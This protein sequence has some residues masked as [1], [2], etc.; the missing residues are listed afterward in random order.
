MWETPQDFF[1]KLNAKY[2]FN[3]DV[4]AIKANA[5]EETILLTGWRKHIVK[6]ERDV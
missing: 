6:A 3:T 4:C 5:K 1:D 2:K